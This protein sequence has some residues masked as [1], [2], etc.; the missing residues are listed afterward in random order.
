MIFFLWGKCFET[1]LR[2]WTWPTTNWRLEAF[3][4]F[5]QPLAQKTH[6]GQVCTLDDVRPTF[7]GWFGGFAVG[8]FKLDLLV[9]LGLYLQFWGWIQS[10]QGAGTKN[11]WLS[12]CGLYSAEADALIIFDPTKSSGCDWLVGWLVAVVL[13]VR[14]CKSHSWFWAL[15]PAARSLAKALSSSSRL[16][17]LVLTDNLLGPKAGLQKHA[18]RE[19]IGGSLRYCITVFFKMFFPI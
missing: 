16:Q 7:F 18:W 15:G 8:G 19:E 11:M 5:S 2:S 14:G 13:H 3:K 4:W 17:E 9:N 12:S 10:Q 6:I 1:H